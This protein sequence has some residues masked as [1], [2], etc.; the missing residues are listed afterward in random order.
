[1]PRRG[2]PGPGLRRGRRH[3]APGGRGRPGR[4]APRTA[5][6]SP[7]ALR[8]LHL[9]LFWLLESF[10]G[11]G[12][13]TLVGF[14][15][16]M[17]SGAVVLAWLY[18]RTGSVLA[19]ACWHATYNLGSATL[20]ARGGVAAAVTTVVIVQAVVLIVLE[21]VRGGGVLVARREQPAPR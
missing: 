21:V 4:L 8:P 20:A 18:D 1:M 13:A 9:P 11:F 16:G 12:P 2:R 5:V 14:L 10:R 3:I 7:G 6:P 15:I 19:V 17:F